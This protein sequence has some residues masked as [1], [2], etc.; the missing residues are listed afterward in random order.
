MG[1]EGGAEAVLGGLGCG[2]SAWGLGAFLDQV[3]S[4]EACL[5][6]GVQQYSHVGGAML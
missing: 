6:S 2:S 4:S 5:A 1:A 3:H